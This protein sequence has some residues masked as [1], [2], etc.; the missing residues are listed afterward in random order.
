M[1]KNLLTK[2][3]NNKKGFTLIELIVVIAILGI[4]AALAIPRFTGVRDDAAKAALLADSRSLYSQLEVEY[5]QEG[6]YPATFTPEG[7]Y[8]G[9]VAYTLTDADNYSLTYD[10][11]V[12]T[13]TFSEDSDM[14]ALTPTKK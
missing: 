10:D 4:L 2:L 9:T 5:A 3:K 12:W 13:I 8:G 1:N 7:T 11:G 6:K 14:T